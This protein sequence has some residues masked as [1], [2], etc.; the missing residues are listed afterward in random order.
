MKKIFTLTLSLLIGAAAFGQTQYDELVFSLEQYEGS[1]RTMAMGNAFT[2][3]GGDLGAIGLNPASTGVFRCSQAGFTPSI[4]FHDSNSG[5]LGLQTKATSN[6]F[7]VPNTG[8]VLS[9]DTNNYSGLLNYNFGITLTRKANFNSITRA[10]GNTSASSYVASI[11]SDMANSGIPY[12]NIDLEETS[13]PFD[14]VSS[15]LWPGILMYN[16]YVVDLDRYL[17]LD[18]AAYIPNTYSRN[19]LQ[20][21]HIPGELGQE[22]YRRT[23]GGIDELTLNFGGNISDKLFFGINLNIEDVDYVVEESVSEYSVNS[24]AFDTGFDQVITNYW[25]ET[26]GVGINAK[27]GLIYNPVAGLRLGATFTTPTYYELTDNYDWTVYSYFDGSNPD[28][29]NCHRETPKGAWDWSF[30]SPMRFSLGA[31]YVI[32]KAGIVSFDYERVNYSSINN[33]FNA[34][35]IFRAGLEGRIADLM[36]IRG[37]YAHYDA[38][39]AGQSDINLVSGGLGFNLGNSFTID[40]AYQ[41][42]LKNNEYFQLYND[43]ADR[44]AG[45]VKAPVGIAERSNGKLS[46]SFSWKF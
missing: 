12:Y 24:R 26:R 29:G 20:Q 40:V 19:T 46:V 2:A 3:L 39:N 14:N 28:Y 18:D 44:Y 31:A 15:D 22:L 35:N 23:R 37:G 7:N 4:N 45:L 16:A 8:I 38:A 13:K 21:L 41:Q 34:S 30:K 36:S 42:M 17:P 5:Y 43:Y 25:R 9:F 32:G 27:F 10:N 11:A 33:S 1:A 6:R